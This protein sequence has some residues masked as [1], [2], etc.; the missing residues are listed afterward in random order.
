[1]L[2]GHRKRQ[3][4]RRD[5]GERGRAGPGPRDQ[6]LSEDEIF[7]YWRAAARMP[8]SLRALL[9]D[10]A[11][12]V[13]ALNE[14]MSKQAHL[15]INSGAD[16]VELVNARARYAKESIEANKVLKQ[17]D[18]LDKIG[19]VDGRSD[20]GKAIQEFFSEQRFDRR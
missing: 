3:T 4:V 19:P 7:S 2:T 12:A 11:R 1:L 16:L 10:S 5:L 13:V 15:L 14:I 6:I 20:V 8:S 9:E 18:D 17:M